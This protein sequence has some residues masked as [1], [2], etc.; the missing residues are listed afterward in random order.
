MTYPFRRGDVYLIQFPLPDQPGETIT[1]YAVNLQEGKI[2][3]KSPTMVCV[4]ITTFK[5]ADRG[6][7]YPTDVV[8]S[9]EE[10]GTRYGAK[11]ICNQI[12]TVVKSIIID[13]K[14]RLSPA[15]MREIDERLLLGVGIIKIEDLE[16]VS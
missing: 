6:R 2:I 14:Y 9:P 10:S 16:A 8:L 5:S 11:V 7:L 4:M 13:F 15:T 12:H 1:K 3:A